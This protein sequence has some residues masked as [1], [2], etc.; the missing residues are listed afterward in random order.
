MRSA[1]DDKIRLYASLFRCRTDVYAPRWESRRD[2][3]SG[4]MPAINC[5]AAL[6]MTTIPS[7]KTAT[8]IWPFVV[9]VTRSSAR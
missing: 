1:P 5:C 4:W 3:R 9:S 2:G 6:S 7:L 8:K